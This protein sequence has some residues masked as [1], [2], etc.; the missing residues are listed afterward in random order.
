M[1]NEFKSFKEHA[2]YIVEFEKEILDYWMKSSNPF[3]RALAELV[4]WEAGGE[5]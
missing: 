4:Y 5:K 1:L 2:I 3:D